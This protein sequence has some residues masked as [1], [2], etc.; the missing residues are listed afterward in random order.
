MGQTRYSL[1][2]STGDVRTQGDFQ[3]VSVTTG[4]DARVVDASALMVALVPGVTVNSTAGDSN[5]IKTWVQPANTLITQID[6]WCALAP[7]VATGDIGYEVGTSSGS[8]Q[9]V[10]N[11]I[12]E[13]LDGG[14]T[15]VINSVAQ[16]ALVQV[17]QSDTSFVIS[18]QYTGV[19]RDIFCNITNTTNA[20]TEG[21]FTFV[22]SYI[23]LDTTAA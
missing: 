23:N 4:T 21:S 19:A 18:A 9:I 10:A 3:K 13:I 22:I 15:V 6:V 17:T 12:N 16:T 1:L 2:E 5:N 11:I 20:S 14:T 8:G 7:T